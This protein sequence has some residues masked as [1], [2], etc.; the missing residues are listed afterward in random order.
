MYTIKKWEWY[1]NE[2]DL[3]VVRERERGRG[4]EEREQES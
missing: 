3:F 2:K 4:G 1:K